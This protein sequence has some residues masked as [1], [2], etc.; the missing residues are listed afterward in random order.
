MRLLWLWT[1]ITSSK[2][3][4]TIEML[5]YAMVLKLALNCKHNLLWQTVGFCITASWKDVFLC[6]WSTSISLQH[7]HSGSSRHSVRLCSRTNSFIMFNIIRLPSIAHIHVHNS[8]WMDQ[9]RVEGGS[10]P[11]QNRGEPAFWCYSRPTP[12]VGSSSYFCSSAD[13]E[14]NV[15]LTRGAAERFLPRQIDPVLTL[16][17]A[18][19]IL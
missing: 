2:G 3:T 8:S 5:Q 14:S 11:L 16:T 10:N 6:L 17:P 12:G 15:S 19:L 1:K 4:P 13:D 9:N 7:L 18:R